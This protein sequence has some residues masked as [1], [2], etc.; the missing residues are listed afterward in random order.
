MLILSMQSYQLFIY[1]SQ[2]CNISIGKLGTFNFLK[3]RYIYTGSA[4]KNLSSRLER[5]FMKKKK[6]HWHIDFFLNN[7]FT[8]IINVTK[9]QQEECDLNKSS[10]GNVLVNGFGS[11]D[12]KQ[13]CRSHL[14]FILN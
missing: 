6:L 3:G 11:S 4:K 14:K 2:D 9:S 12:C 1:L 5:H 13:L 8:K 10:K 7:K